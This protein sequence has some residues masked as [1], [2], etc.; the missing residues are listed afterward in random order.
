MLLL[1]LTTLSGHAQEIWEAS[2][3]TDLTKD[4]QTFDASESITLTIASILNEKDKEDGK[5]PWQ[6]DA[7]ENLALNTDDCSPK[8]MQILKGMGNPY[9]QD[10]G[11]HWEDTD[12]GRSWR[13]D[14][15]AVKWT[16][17]CGQL[18]LHGMYILVNAK[19][20]GLLKMGVYVNKGNHP[21]YVI[22]KETVKELNHADIDVEFYYQNNT[23]G[24]MIKGKLPADYI[25]QHTN[26]ETQNRPA[27]GYISFSVEAGKSYYVLNPSSQVGLYGYYFTTGGSNEV[28]ATLKVSPEDAGTVTPSATTILSGTSFEASATANAGYRFEG[29]YIDGSQVSTDNPHTFTLNANTEITA[30]FAAQPANIVT[31]FVKPGCE[32]MGH[33]SVSPVG[34]TVDGGMKFNYGTAVTLTAVTHLGHQFSHWED[35]TGQKLSEDAEYSFTVTEDCTVYAVFT[36]LENYKDDLIAFPGCEGYGRFTSGGRAVDGRGSKVYYVTRLD[37]CPDNNLVEGTLRWALKSGDD[38]PRTVLFKVSGTIYLTSTLSGVKPNLTIAGQTAPGG[39]ICIAGYQMK[40]PSNSIVRHIRFRTGDLPNGS[41]SPLDVENIDHIVLDHCSFT[42][43]MEE[44]I[45]VYD[46]DYTTTQWC[47][48]AEGLYYS[49]NVKG[50][51]SYGA[52]WGGEHGTMHHCLFSNNNSRSPRF[53]GVRKNVHDRHVDNEFVNNV[54]YNWGGHNSIY[55][56]E[57]DQ[58][59]DGGDVY[60]R[61]F[62]INNYYRPGPATKDAGGNRHFVSISAEK[63]SELGQ[64]YLS[65][66]KFELNSKWAPNTN[67]WS[68]AVLEKVNAD[69]YYGFASGSNE[70]GFNLYRAGTIPLNQA[71]A[72]KVIMK[73]IPYALSGMSFDES[74]DE[75]FQKVVKQAGASLPRYDEV[76][77]RILA[78]AAGTIDPQ[79]KGSLPE[80]HGSLGYIDTPYDIKLQ[81]H[82]EFAA[83]DEAINQEIDVICYPR[84]QG[85]SYDCQVLDTDGDGLPDAYETSVGLNPNDAADGGKLTANG[86]S[87]LELYINGVADGQI[88][89]T[90]YTKHQTGGTFSGFNAVVGEG[91]AYTTVQAAVDAAPGDGTPYYIFVK[92]GTYEG[93]VQIDKPNIHL[94]GQS[95]QNTI[96]SWNKTN[97]EGGGV[98]KASTVNVTAN[99]VSFDNL[100]LRNTRQNEGQAL[101]LYTKADRIIITNCNLEGWQDTYRTGK[102]GQRHLVRNCK[103]S[104]TTDFIYGAGEAFFDS[105][106]LHVLRESNV[107]V[108]PDHSTA[109]YGYVFRNAVITA[110]KTGSTTALGRPW[111]NTPKVSY[112]NTHL[113]DGVSITPEGWNEMG[114]KPVQ[115]AEYNT[116]DASGKA[117]D[118]SQRRTSFGGTASKALL[119]KTEAVNDYKLDYMLRGSDNWDADWQGFI[120]PAPLF[121]VSGTTASWS[122]PTGFAQCFLVTIDGQATLT[123]ASSMSTSGGKHVTVQAVSAY[124]VLGEIASSGSPS[125]IGSMVNS[126]PVTA[127]EY[128]TP[129]GQQHSRL[130][131]GTNIIRETLSDG[132]TRTIKV[133]AK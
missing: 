120:L 88:D 114:G 50:H 107:I 4:V 7:T 85:D 10:A 8:F 43:S 129:D 69:N 34:T 115:M 1:L 3:I 37:D 111:N 46:C 87:N 78:E 25:I 20:S 118:L 93:H 57:C 28:T 130:Q 128:F 56:G 15:N 24:S 112:I 2:S 97:E 104:G 9:I 127:R 49:K 6:L 131:H 47:I 14:P 31:G 21:L 90:L 71:I 103:I 29:W 65:G 30:Q 60:S 77:A 123:T 116:M 41:M 91:E 62:M 122:D 92:A 40:L 18:P 51:R 5:N 95:K 66:N 70:R 125:A 126:L 113:T 106:T 108:A 22:E 48:F 94:T 80:S 53:N 45:T 110:A 17:G 96:I 133:V 121:S 16:P 59:L 44:N 132:T 74:A 83:L 68:N 12:N 39:G 42:W 89:A 36:L 13:D 72:D 11:G 32:A 52:Q 99:D 73:E 105:D 35:G 81:S 58:T 119:S 27:L 100:T 26:G 19:A 79:F 38:T 109:R 23:F 84:L 124:G 67:I 101:A 102:D 86:Y 54:V 117:V 82:D 61:T 33:V 75:A 98:D 63:E 76:D 55:G 64:W